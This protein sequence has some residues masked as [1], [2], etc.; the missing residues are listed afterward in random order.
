MKICIQIIS[1]L[2]FTL[3]FFSFLKIKKLGNVNFNNPY[4]WLSLFILELFYIL[5]LIS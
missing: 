3:K 4:I 1:K 2:Y 5:L